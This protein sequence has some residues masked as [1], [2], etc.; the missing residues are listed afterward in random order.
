MGASEK[1]EQVK[2]KK[3]KRGLGLEGRELGR[4]KRKESL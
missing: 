2:K 3:Y 1:L 4:G